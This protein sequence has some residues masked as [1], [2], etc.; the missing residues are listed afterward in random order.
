MQYG[1]V[2]FEEG[3]YKG[4]VY[5]DT[6]TNEVKAT[7][8]GVLR[9]YE[10]DSYI[11]FGKWKKN[12]MTL[13]YKAYDSG[14]KYLG[15]FYKGRYHGKGCHIDTDGN[16][17]I[18]DFAGGYKDGFGVCFYSSEVIYMG[19]WRDDSPHGEGYYSVKGGGFN[20]VLFDYGTVSK[21]LWKPDGRKYSNGIIYYGDLA[22]SGDYLGFGEKIA[23]H[24]GRQLGNWLSR[25][26]EGIQA[27][28]LD[29]GKGGKILEV[30]KFYIKGQADGYVQKIY[31][32]GDMI[33]GEYSSGNHNGHVIHVYNNGQCLYI[34]EKENGK[35]QH[36]GTLITCE[37]YIESGLW[38]DDYFFGNET[39]DPAR[40]TTSRVY[41]GLLNGMRKPKPAPTSSYTSSSFDTYSATSSSS[42]SSNSESTSSYTSTS[43]SSYSSTSDASYTSSSSSSYAKTSSSA[44]SSDK[45]AKSKEPLYYENGKY[46]FTDW[47]KKKLEDFNYKNTSSEIIITGLYTP[48]A[49]VVIP[50]FVTTIESGAFKAQ[51]CAVVESIVVPSS[52]Y[53]MKGS[54]FVGCT[55]LK[56]I[57]LQAK[58]TSIPTKAFAGTALEYIV[59]PDEVKSIRDGAFMGCKNLK[60][61]YAPKGC[62]VAEGAIPEG[63]EILDK[64][65]FKGDEYEANLSSASKS[66][67][68]KATNEAANS[69]VGKSAN[70]T[71]STVGKSANKTASGVGN[72]ANKTA[73]GVGNAADKTAPSS[74]K[75]VKIG[76]KEVEIP[77]GFFYKK[78]K[79]VRVFIGEGKEE[80]TVIIPEGITWYSSRLNELNDPQILK[81]KKLILPS[82]LKEVQ[83]GLENITSLEEVDFSKCT[84]KIVPWMI[85][86]GTGVKRITLPSSI[87]KIQGWAFEN[88]KQ[89]EVAYM[90]GVVSIATDA[91]RGCTKLKKI[92]VKRRCVFNETALRDTS[93]VKI[94]YV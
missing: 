56:K 38:R 79:N 49:H 58:I 52:V 21:I 94:E 80:G 7:G 25:Y 78:V 27:F 14:E 89:L 43:S 60:R 57:D 67:S 6:E 70:K 8:Y 47:A 19:N 88:C 66:T 71:T 37:G 4:E 59:L 69:T 13:G 34:G 55:N 87:E 10:G 86:S 77:S 16:Y 9:V 35:K 54:C 48:K 39:G 64:S 15:D 75:T 12:H 18:G 28:G 61:I 53:F 20:K 83:L 32:N 42:S 24:G 93:G 62:K 76:R 3:E 26:V 36:G 51:K 1:K 5:R 85:L 41:Y 31:A 72:A 45:A 65:L 68:A 29:Y 23:T 82:T 73:S 50:D 33:M 63:C 40:P 30:G 17:Y 84:W 22:Y 81:M 90:P 44:S 74:L 92:T 91:F 11:Y 46:H 2:I